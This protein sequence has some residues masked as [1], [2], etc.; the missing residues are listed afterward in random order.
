MSVL[1]D[2]LALCFLSQ[3]V[4]PSFWSTYMAEE[5]TEVSYT[6]NFEALFEGLVDPKWNDECQL[7]FFEYCLLGPSRTL[8]QLMETIKQKYPE[9][10]FAILNFETYR[11]Y[12]W[13]CK[14]NERAHELDFRIFM[15]DA[16]SIMARNHAMNVRHARLGHEMLDMAAEHLQVLRAK[17]QLGATATVQLLREAANVERLANEAELPREQ[18]QAAPIV[19]ISIAT[20]TT[21]VPQIQGVIIDAGN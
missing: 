2:D 10:N 15:A 11:N 13:K 21:P 17:G 5:T 1:A 12:S 19:N 4:C 16:T 7:L 6:P 3:V 14:W 8:R 18:A 9:S 20:D